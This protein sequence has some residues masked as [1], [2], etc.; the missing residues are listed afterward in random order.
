MIAS[1]AL[2]LSLIAAG[3]WRGERCLFAT[4]AVSSRISVTP[5]AS[6]Q[7]SLA[8]E[9]ALLASEAKPGS[10]RSAAVLANL[11]WFRITQNAYPQTPLVAKKEGGAEEPDQDL[12][13]LAIV[14][15]RAVA[16]D[17][18][19]WFM[20]MRLGGVLARIGDETGSRS[21]FVGSMQ[22][23]PL[24][25]LT[26]QEYADSLRDLG[27]LDEA[28]HY[29]R[30]SARFQDAG[31][32]SRQLNVLDKLLRERHPDASMESEAKAGRVNEG[33]ASAPR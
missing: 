12:S 14:L 10:A 23:L 11:L 33:R 9:E 4:E 1:L 20:L 26:Y 22:R 25:A 21:A 31:T 19:N 8:I 28:G 15:R 3:N 5:P 13:R 24:Y 17:P 2:F 18:E 32:V 27:S 30:V 29:Y 16:A 6:E 7:L